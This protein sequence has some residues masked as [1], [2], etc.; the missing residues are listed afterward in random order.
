MGVLG[1]TKGGGRRALGVDMTDPEAAT[2][3]KG[4]EDSR[5]RGGISSLG[6]LEGG[7]KIS[8]SSCMATY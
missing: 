4:G 2:G 6:F 5:S 1:L 8:R 7:S 3:R